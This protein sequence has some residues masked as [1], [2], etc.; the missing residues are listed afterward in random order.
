MRSLRR[1]RKQEREGMV[2]GI[3]YSRKEERRKLETEMEE[4]LYW[5]DRE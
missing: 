3:M 5:E 2:S 1:G 4:L